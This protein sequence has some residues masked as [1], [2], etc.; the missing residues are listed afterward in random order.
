MSCFAR[1]AQKAGAGTSGGRRS[2]SAVPNL[3]LM[4]APGVGKGT[5]AS[6]LA[7]A[8]NVPT[9][10][11]GDLVRAEIK[12]GSALGQKIA[13]INDRG[14]LVDDDLITEMARARLNEDDAKGGF[15]LDGFPR[16]SGQAEALE[17]FRHVE[18]AVNLDIDTEVLVQKITSR[19]VCEDCGNGYNIARIH[20]GDIQMEPL[21]PEKEGVCDKCGGKLVQRADDTPE[22]VRNR[23]EIYNAETAPLIE[24]YRERGTLAE[25]S[26]KRGVDDLPELLELIESRLA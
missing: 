16:T 18:L 19:R 8:L 12:S 2:L 21:L 6:R 23:L 7:P 14:E 1:K 13:D 9:I 15:I 20:K 17:T 10:S 3:L 26:V 22:I 11:T 24:F 4:G 25:F 5:F